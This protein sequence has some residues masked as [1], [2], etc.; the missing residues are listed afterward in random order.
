MRHAKAFIG[1]EFYSIFAMIRKLFD[2]I[3]KACEYYSSRLN[4]ENAYL[5][6][7]YSHVSIT[8][9]TEGQ[10]DGG[11]VRVY[12]DSRD[13]PPAAEFK[14]DGAGWGVFVTEAIA[15]PDRVSTTGLHQ[16]FLEFDGD[17]CCADIYDVTFFH[18]TEDVPARVVNTEYNRTQG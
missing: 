7:N 9:G 3:A 18:T 2:R 15:L 8:F 13:N 4:F 6:D 5:Y 1:L 16:V 10:W 11:V 14:L 12:I 17:G